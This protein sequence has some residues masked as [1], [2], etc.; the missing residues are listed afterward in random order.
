[1]QERFV[2]TSGDNEQV[3]K[4]FHL[5]LP[6]KGKPRKV[7]VVACMH[8]LLPILNAICKFGQAWRKDFSHP[9]RSLFWRQKTLAFEHSCWIAAGLRPRNDER[10][11]CNDRRGGFRND[12]FFRWI[13]LAP[14]LYTPGCRG[15][16]FAPDL[17][18]N[19][20]RSDNLYKILP[21]GKLRSVVY[22]AGAANTR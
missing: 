14:R 6:D 5:R 22:M 11:F 21:A 10:V 20:I 19:V 1:L 2:A 3:L 4:A 9:R 16:G 12:G 8:K 17:Q 18:K 13:P 7:A 15:G